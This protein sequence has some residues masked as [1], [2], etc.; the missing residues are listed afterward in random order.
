MQIQ[1]GIGMS[2]GSFA[3]KVNYK[4]KNITFF[5]VWT[6]ATLEIL[7]YKPPFHLEDKKAELLN[8]FKSAVGTSI[9]VNPY[10]W[11]IPFSV[12]KD[13][14]VFRRLLEVLSWAINEIQAL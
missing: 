5:R 10:C 7:A 4:G 1:C 6:N 14:I 2:Q 3:P 9:S 11:Y 8:K 13:E 12:L